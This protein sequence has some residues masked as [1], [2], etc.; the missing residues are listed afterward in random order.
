MR[1]QKQWEVTEETEKQTQ[2]RQGE[3]SKEMTGEEE[4]EKQLEQRQE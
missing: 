1:H 4:T 3:Q 2:L